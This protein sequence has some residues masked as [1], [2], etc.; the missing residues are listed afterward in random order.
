MVIF[1]QSDLKVFHKLVSDRLNSL[2]D[3]KFSQANAREL[4]ALLTECNSHAH[5]CA[6][7]KVRP[8]KVHYSIDYAGG[9]SDLLYTKHKIILDEQQEL[10]LQNILL[11]QPLDMIPIPSL[12]GAPLEAP[13]IF[14]QLNSDLSEYLEQ[15]RAFLSKDTQPLSGE[16]MV[17]AKRILGTE[18]L[19]SE[20]N[21]DEIVIDAII[22]LFSRQPEHKFTDEDWSE[23][24][25]REFNTWQKDNKALIKRLKSYAK[26]AAISAIDLLSNGANL[27]FRA[28]KLGDI[29]LNNETLELVSQYSSAAYLGI[30]KV[31][32]VDM[33]LFRNELESDCYVA[34]VR[35]F[36]GIYDQGKWDMVGSGNACKVDPRN[37][38]EPSL[39]NVCDAHSAMMHDV[40]NVFT[41]WVGDGE[42]K[43]YDTFQAL[44]YGSTAITRLVSLST[45]CQSP[46][47][48]A[49]IAQCLCDETL[50]SGVEYMIEEEG[51]V[52]AA[53][54]HRLPYF[55]ETALLIC[56]VCGPRYKEDQPME[57][58]FSSG[59]IPVVDRI[60]LTEEEV[61][62]FGKQTQ[63]Y[64]NLKT[65]LSEYIS[66]ISYD[67]FSYAFT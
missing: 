51:I 40:F 57:G 60:P 18:S 21:P 7:L 37:T 39:F 16:H 44:R 31:T 9:F 48:E 23:E 42:Y 65:H 14:D 35:V 45:H 66:V 4:T 3:R 5:L 41:S 10:E 34:S 22:N 62:E 55:T 67:P 24:W 52:D 8:V 61:I 32:E 26:H 25:E 49:Y 53:D 33:Q 47:L 1:N 27:E 29:K 19:D 12:D 59:R 50:L 43:N 58:M 20:E 63:E 15:S 56:E 2:L 28:Q 46:K 11:I 36:I 30:W 64:E 54:R 17:E 38:E 13:G 6:E